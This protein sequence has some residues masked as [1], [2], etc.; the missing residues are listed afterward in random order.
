[1]VHSTEHGVEA[2][3]PVILAG[4][5]LAYLADEATTGGVGGT[6]L[7]G[8]MILPNNESVAVAVDMTANITRVIGVQADDIALVRTATAGTHL[9]TVTDEAEDMTI[10]WNGG[11]FTDTVLLHSHL[12]SASGPTFVA[13]LDPAGPCLLVQVG[14]RLYFK[15]V[16]PAPLVAPETSI[17]Y[18]DAGLAPTTLVRVNSDLANTLQPTLIGQDEGLIF[19]S[20]D[21]TIE[22]RDLNLDSDPTDTNVLGLLDGTDPAASIYTVPVAM[23]DAEGPVRGLS[24]G[25]ND[26]LV[27][28]LV[29]EAS[30]GTFSVLN[31]E[32][33]K[34]PPHCVMKADNDNDDEVLHFLQFS[35]FAVLGMKGLVRNTNLVG[36]DQI[37]AVRSPGGAVYIA[38]VGDEV[39]QGQCDVNQDGDQADAILRWVEVVLPVTT[40]TPVDPFTDPN[41]LLAVARVPGGPEGSVELEHR[42]ICVVS[43]F[44]DGRDHDGDPF[45]DNDLVAW[46]DPFAP[47]PT[48]VFDHTNPPLP[49]L[50]VVGTGWVGRG[51]P[52]DVIPIAFPEVFSGTGGDLNGDGDATDSV[53]S[54]ASFN[55]GGTEL[56]FPGAPVALDMGNAGIEVSN[57]WTYFRVDETEDGR[58]WNGDTDKDDM[59]LLRA[60]AAA[61]HSTS[62]V[63][64]LNNVLGPAI[65]RADPATGGLGI[66]FISDEGMEL[67]DFNEDGDFVDLVLRWQVVN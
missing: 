54:L 55:F 2:S 19:L 57:G 60:P 7:N 5:W 18:V 42:L 32:A 66:A 37:L 38:T 30:E 63:G 53:P 12:E 29:D 45:V 10:D 56:D 9:F 61:L 25:A 65:F 33:T 15:D 4:G 59:V 16:P 26:W 11:G 62:Y 36:A 41:E 50:N 51:G 39:D 49:P 47:T 67:V 8:N 6:D 22:G 13:T 3:T 1:L 52:G 20:L 28:V 24:L 35:E 23:R 40:T 48:W 44:D 17:A 14:E 58:D 34:H 46:L 27:G 31:G 43:E 64:T 21:E